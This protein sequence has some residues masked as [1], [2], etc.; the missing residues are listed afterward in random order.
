MGHDSEGM[1]T[2]CLALTVS[3]LALTPCLA[4]SL[5]NPAAANANQPVK[6]ASARD[7]FTLRGAEVV[8]TRNGVTSKVEREFVFAN[9]LRVAAN[10][11]AKLRDGSTVTLGPNQLLTFDGAIHEVALTPEGVAPLSSVD[12]GPAP[13]PVVK[14]SVRDGIRTSAGG[15]QITRNGVTEKVTGDVR[16]PNGVTVRSDGTVVLG[17]GN[18]TTLRHGQVLDLHGVM[19][20]D[21]QA[22]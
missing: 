19:Q 14:P 8:I 12:T 1:K 18:T 7:G 2:I 17:N 9:G 3:V 11:T 4:Q 15:V 22:R 21:P 10:G 13:Q 20:V 5:S 6:G 16:L